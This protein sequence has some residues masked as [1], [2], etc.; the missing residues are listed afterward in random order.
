MGSGRRQ[1]SPKRSAL[2]ALWGLRFRRP[3][4][5]DGSAATILDA[6][7]RHG[8]EAQ[9]A[10]ARVGDLSSGDFVA[11]MAFLESL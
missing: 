6:L 5:H 3:L 2:P 10:R 11:L 7:V 1:V 9:T 4:L 8:N